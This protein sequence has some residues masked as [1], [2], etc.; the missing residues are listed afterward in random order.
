M[1]LDPEAHQRRFYA[2]DDAALERL[3]AAGL[4]VPVERPGPLV[5]EHNVLTDFYRVRT[6]DPLPVARRVAGQSLLLHAFPF[7]D[8]QVPERALDVLH[9][10]ARS[11]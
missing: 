7:F 4:P 2:L 1:R 11:L 8:D 5:Q 6:P 3:H 10:L 9:T